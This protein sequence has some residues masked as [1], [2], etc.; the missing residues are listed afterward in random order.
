MATGT[1]NTSLGGIFQALMTPAV[2]AAVNRERNNQGFIGSPTVQ[3]I[4][5]RDPMMVAIMGAAGV[6][7][8]TLDYG[9]ASLVST[10]EGSDPAESDV[11]SAATTITPARR[12]LLRKLSDYA[13]A[14]LAGLLTGDL[15]PAM[16]NA[17]IFDGVAA[18]SNGLAGSVKT[19]ASSMSNIVGTSGAPAAWN[20]LRDGHMELVEYG[21]T[22]TVAIYDLKGIKDLTN[23]VAS[24]GGVLANDP[25]LLQFQ[26]TMR[27]GFVGRFFNGCNVY[28]L[29]GLATTG[30]DT[31]GAIFG[32]AG[33]GIKHE[34]VPLGFGAEVIADLGFL[35]M[36]AKRGA[37]SVS[38]IHTV[39]HNGVG[40]REQ[41][42]CRRI[43]YATT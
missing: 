39:S 6:Q 21:Q 34:A 26:Q 18:W 27:P 40:I 11:T 37:G 35:T 33:V 23:D 24:L 38:E 32:A 9:Q 22:E 31:Y 28:M 4:L 7:F 20:H 1:L 19:L 5:A 25:Q 12:A 2:A 3:A 43:R 17:L 41:A 42:A 10:A 14:K 29:P 13:N 8:T 36:E 30:G 15:S 16:Y